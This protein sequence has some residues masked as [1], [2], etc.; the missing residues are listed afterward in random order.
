MI[1]LKGTSLTSAYGLV[2]NMDNLILKNTL[3]A[4]NNGAITNPAD[5]A[6]D[7][8]IARM[9]NAGL[10]AAASVSYIEAVRTEK[11]GPLAVWEDG[12]LERLA[13]KTMKRFPSAVAKLFPESESYN[14]HFLIAFIQSYKV[15]I[16]A[17]EKIADIIFYSEASD[18][19]HIPP[20]ARLTIGRSLSLFHNTFIL[21]NPIAQAKEEEYTMQ[22]LLTATV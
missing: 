22:R 18:N 9:I 14:N 8:D 17:N 11:K 21:T 1:N 7:N 6:V 12:T 19:T 3:Y 20:I 4:I 15:M 5:I 10:L 13:T 2:F 16:K